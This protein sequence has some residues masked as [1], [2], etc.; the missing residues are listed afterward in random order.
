MVLREGE[1]E[2]EPEGVANCGGE[3][4]AWIAG[5]GVL[6]PGGE[7]LGEGLEELPPSPLPGEAEREGERVP[8]GLGCKEG[9]GAREATSEALGWE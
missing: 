4:V 5:L 1:A 8:L 7:G 9:E 2:A 6:T 3:G